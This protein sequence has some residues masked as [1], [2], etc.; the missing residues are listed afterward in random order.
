MT[1]NGSTSTTTDYAAGFVY[2][3][4][5]LQFAGIEE[6][7]MIYNDQSGAFDREGFLLDHLGN[8]RVVFADNNSDGVA[9]VVQENHYYPFGLSMGALNYTNTL[10]NK[11]KYNLPFRQA[12][13]KELDDE[14]GLR[15]YDYGFRRYDPQIGR[16]HVVDALAEKYLSSSPYAYVKNNPVSFIDPNGLSR[17]MFGFHNSAGN[18][19]GACNFGRNIF[20]PGNNSTHNNWENTM[21]GIFHHANEEYYGEWKENVRAGNIVPYSSYHMQR[22]Y[23]DVTGI[24]VAG[25][26]E[27][28]S[29]HTVEGEEVNLYI[30]LSGNPRSDFEMLMF[31]C[32]YYPNLYPDK[33][34]NYVY[35]DGE[36]LDEVASS[37]GGDLSLAG[38]YTHFQIGGGETLNINMSSVD[39]GGATQRE[40]G[41][42]GMEAGDI[43]GIQ[44]FRA[45]SLTTAGLAFG[46]VRM[47]AHGNNQFSIISDESARFDFTPLIDRASTLERNVGNIIGA[48]INYNVFLMPITP[49]APVIPSIFG[50]PFDI[51]FHGTTTIPR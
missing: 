35:E 42:A 8:V 17:L 46:R 9:E 48:S 44:L 32:F 16:W 49:L 13:G 31:I 41:L 12:G 21:D 50:G 38:L 20:G 10:E 7:R 14:A 28:T 5:N 22:K 15:W 27:A 2:I 23:K 18:A 6:G 51:N 33:D 11:F 47:M 29:A 36:G 26:P 24:A 19:F 37:G 45:N 3:D 30:R 43:R 25:T 4:N 39:F 40:L 34:F 1:N